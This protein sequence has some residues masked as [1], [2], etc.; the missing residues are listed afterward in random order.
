MGVRIREA[1]VPGDWWGVC[2]HRHKLVTLKPGLGAAQ[3]RSTL[4]HELGHAAYGHTGHHPKT[5]RLADRW[6]AKRLL[7]IDLLFSHARL[8][9]DVR[10]LAASLDVMPWVIE[11][12]VEILSKNELR[13]LICKLRDIHG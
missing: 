12:Y 1:A 4:A 11:T 13:W 9:V 6:A 5:E 7:T 2:D 10:E 8:G 3:R